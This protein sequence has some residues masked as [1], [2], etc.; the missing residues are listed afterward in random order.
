MYSGFR[1]LPVT[2]PR[3]LK[4]RKQVK[5]PTPTTD[6]NISSSGI[7]KEGTFITLWKLP[8]ARIF[9]EKALKRLWTYTRK[10][11]YQSANWLKITNNNNNNDRLTAFDPGQPG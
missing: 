4:Q 2:K 11:I 8:H 9:N 6:F 3:V 7:L 10:H 5:A 1:A